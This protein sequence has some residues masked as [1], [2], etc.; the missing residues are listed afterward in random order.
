MQGGCC[1]SPAALELTVSDTLQSFGLALGG[2]T[3]SRFKGTAD[4]ADDR[5][6]G[7]RPR[8][9]NP[10][11]TSSRSGRTTAP[12]RL[13]GSLPTHSGQSADLDGGQSQINLPARSGTSKCCPIADGR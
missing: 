1:R 13:D 5:G 7:R 4:I 11:L 12:T 2:A 6:G 10:L 3:S 9:F 8:P